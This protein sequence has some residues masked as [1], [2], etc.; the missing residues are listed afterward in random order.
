M[1][2]IVRE[3]GAW[4]DRL[5]TRTS[6]QLELHAEASAA[7]RM[8][9]TQT[10]ILLGSPPDGSGFSKALA[11][12]ARQWTEVSSKVQALAHMSDSDELRILAKEC[13]GLAEYCASL[14]MPEP[15]Q[16]REIFRKAEDRDFAQDSRY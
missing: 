3:L 5:N 16:V 8:A 9:T 14:K 12:L 7:F 11:D 15:G 4:V 1:L 10:R 6:Q 2:E 13:M